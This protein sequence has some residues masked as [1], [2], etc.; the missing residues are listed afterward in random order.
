MLE[1]QRAGFGHQVVL[2]TRLLIRTCVVLVCGGLAGC[3][4]DQGAL[5][6]AAA[7]EPVR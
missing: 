5:S 3:L 1:R 4:A 2:K 7:G 6:T